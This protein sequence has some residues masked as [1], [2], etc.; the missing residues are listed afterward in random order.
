MNTSLIKDK[1]IFY[2]RRCWLYGSL[3]FWHPVKLW[4]RILKIFVLFVLCTFLFIWAVSVNL[5]WLFG[6]SPGLEQLQRPQVALASTLYTSD[7]KILGRYYDENRTPV[8]QW[9]IAPVV[10]DALVATEDARF[11]EHA[12]I[13]FQVLPSIIFDALGGEKRGGST[14]TQQLAKNLYKTR[15]GATSGLFGHI[16][17]LRTVNGKIKEWITAVKLERAFTKEEIMTKYLNIVPFGHNAFGIYTA[18]RTFFRT[19]PDKLTITQAAMLVGML[20]ATTYFSPVSNPDRALNR[21]NVVLN[22]MTKYGY[23]PIEKGELL[24]KKPLGV[25]Y[26]VEQ[27]YSG[28]ATY[29]RGIMNN[30]LNEWCDNNGYD[31][32]RDGLKIYTTIDSRVQKHAEEALKE[33]MRKL[34]KR[35]NEH[36]KGKSPW[37]DDRDRELPHYIENAIKR[38]E[39]YKFLKK[40]HGDNEGAIQAALNKPKA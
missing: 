7:G 6:S 31:L 20:K 32:Y 30:Y 19:T 22:Q 35:F 34:Q 8:D 36:W 3:S 38:T 28:P 9:Q 10:F 21:R 12:G 37:V 27:T 11:Y 23:L 29:F 15:Q 1:V 13:D 17:G 24:T 16:P 5:F 4:E 39:A 33:H 25:K 18:S 40:K 26:H 2:I 14:I